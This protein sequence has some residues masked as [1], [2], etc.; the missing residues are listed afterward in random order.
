MKLAQSGLA[1]TPPINAVASR[2]RECDGGMAGAVACALQD[3][4]VDL[5]FRPKAPAGMEANWIETMPG[6]ASLA[7]VRLYG[8]TEGL[9]DKS[10][11]LPDIEPIE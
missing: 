10:W 4:S 8:T 9:Y 1:I 2:L 3:R 6:K 7:Y 5:Y 11:S